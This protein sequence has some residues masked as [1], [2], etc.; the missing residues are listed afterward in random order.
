MQPCNDLDPFGKPKPY[1]PSKKEE[2]KSNFQPDQQD[3]PAHLT[4]T[5]SP[6]L[7]LEEAS[8]ETTREICT[9]KPARYAQVMLKHQLQDNM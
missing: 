2:E 6:A 3:D 8:P 9:A 4:A 7:T 5:W 1:F